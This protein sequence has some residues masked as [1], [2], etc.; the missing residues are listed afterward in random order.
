MKKKKLIWTQWVLN[1][2]WV[3]DILKVIFKIENKNL[4]LINDNYDGSKVKGQTILEP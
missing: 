3:L 2:K 1:N 4:V